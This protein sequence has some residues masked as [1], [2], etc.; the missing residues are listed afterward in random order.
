MHG[1][2]LA[3]RARANFLQLAVRSILCSLAQGSMHALRWHERFSAQGAS[4]PVL[5]F[6]G[7]QVADSGHV[8]SM[9]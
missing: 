1:V 4:S 8:Y 7:D 9:Q 5:V 6:D 3:R 2:L